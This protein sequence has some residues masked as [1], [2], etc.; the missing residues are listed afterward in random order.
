MN[1]T[2]KIPLE[3]EKKNTKQEKEKDYFFNQKYYNTT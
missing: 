3:E 2:K 1:P